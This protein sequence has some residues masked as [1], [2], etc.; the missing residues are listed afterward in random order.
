[1]RHEIR[2]V[3]TLL[4]LFA[5][6]TW[7]C[8][9]EPVGA[10]PA[11]SDVVALEVAHDPIELV[12][13]LDTSMSMTRHQLALARSLM[14]HLIQVMDETDQFGLV[15]IADQATVGIESSSATP[16]AKSAW[17]A[18]IQA[19]DDVEG[20]TN[21]EN[22]LEFTR[23]LSPAARIVLI[24]DGSPTWGNVVAEE[25]ARSAKG[26]D[27][28]TVGVG[29]NNEPLLRELGHYL[30]LTNPAEAARVLITHDDLDGHRET[31]PSP[32]PERRR[33]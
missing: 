10:L 19:L 17:L 16:E 28:W 15:L 23:T 27:L 24:T 32:P 31:A 6:S 8:S 33:R 26:L 11:D 22:A 30:S 5:A 20:L 25:L 14:E 29:R 21:L 12:V 18:R 1:M 4:T 2:F 7:S 9:P 13:M 3:L